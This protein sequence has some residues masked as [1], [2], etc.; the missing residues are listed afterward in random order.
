MKRIFLCT[1][2]LLLPLSGCGLSFLQPAEQTPTTISISEEDIVISGEVIPEPEN[3]I[4]SYTYERPHGIIES[5]YVRILPGTDVDMQFADYWIDLYKE[6]GDPEE[7]IMT[8][9]EIA[10]GNA[11]CESKIYVDE[12][13]PFTQMSLVDTM[14]GELVRALVDCVTIPEAPNNYYYQ[15]EKTPVKFWEDAAAK[16]N[17]DTIEDIVTLKYGYF[18]CREDLRAYPDNSFVGSSPDDEFFDEFLMAE[19]MPYV[20]VVI[21]HEDVTGDWYYVVTY[22]FCG[23]IEKEYVALCHS[24]DEWLKYME[25]DEWLVVTGREIRLP[26]AQGDERISGL[27]LP[28]G[29]KMPLVKASDAPESI[30]GRTTYGNYVVKLKVRGDNGYLEEKYALISAAEDVSPG[31]LPYTT[32]NVLT[33]AFKLI[34]DR[35]GWGGMHH[36]NDCSG[37]IRELYLCFGFELPRTSAVQLLGENGYPMNVFEDTSNEEKIETIKSLAPGSILYFPGHVMIYLGTVDNEPYVLSA[38][39]T[40]SN[41]DMPNGATISTNSVLVTNIAVTRRWNGDTWLHDISKTLE[42]R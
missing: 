26:D 37:I 38:V 42:I 25:A 30:N 20:P 28:M 6:T 23:W 14:D 35:Y 29:T 4:S 33:Q 10:A 1:I 9:E 24:R 40:L 36:S 41:P 34:G 27:L 17:L 18:T 15:G 2:V 8:Y 32:E 12:F 16:R 22:G 31:F 19:A 5:D 39:S 21:I 3:E 13:E 11:K 7:I